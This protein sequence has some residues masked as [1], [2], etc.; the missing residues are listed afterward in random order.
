M[1]PGHP[2]L[3]ARKLSVPSP[4]V[5]LACMWERGT[6]GV[7]PSLHFFKCLPNHCPLPQ[8]LG[9]PERDIGPGASGRGMGKVL[10]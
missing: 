4:A 9:S 8:P 6:G 1:A 2:G 10:D 3:S 7:A 5:A